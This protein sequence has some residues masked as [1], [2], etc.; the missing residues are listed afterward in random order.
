MHGMQ[1][2]GEGFC[3]R[4]KELSRTESAWQC[5][6]LAR[7][8]TQCVGKTTVSWGKGSRAGRCLCDKFQGCIAT[9]G[10]HLGANGFDRFQE[11]VSSSSTTTTATTA[12]TTSTTT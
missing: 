5:L 6:Q 8:D 9:K 1:D 3:S 12:T 7:V 4:F 10:T 11:I 2:V